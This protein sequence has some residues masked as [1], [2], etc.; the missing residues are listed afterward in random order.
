ME[1]GF[2]YDDFIRT[3]EKRHTEVV[4]D[5]LKDLYQRATQFDLP[6][7]HITIKCLREAGILSPQGDGMFRWNQ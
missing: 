7:P 5:I 6:H 4:Q 3:T 1:L 2:A